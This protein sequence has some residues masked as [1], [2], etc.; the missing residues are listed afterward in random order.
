MSSD[1]KTELSV[2][3]EMADKIMDATCPKNKINKLSVNNSND[4]EV[5]GLRSEINE[6]KEDG[7]PD[8]IKKR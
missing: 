2:L 5:V 6:L 3:A 4:S 8:V 1:D 7:V